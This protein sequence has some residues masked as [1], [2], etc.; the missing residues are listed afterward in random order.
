M[1]G[2]M[3]GGGIKSKCKEFGKGKEWFTVVMG[4]FILLLKTFIVQW[5]YNQ[6]WP[7]FVMN[8]GLDPARFS[9][10]TFYEAFLFV[11]FIEFLF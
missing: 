11:I 10:F 1:L 9:P 7:K 3:I 2:S 4:L 5:A 8:S 6:I